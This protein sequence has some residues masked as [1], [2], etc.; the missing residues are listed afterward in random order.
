MYRA[1]PGHEDRYMI[2]CQMG[3]A[4]ALEREGRIEEA[5][6]VLSEAISLVPEGLEDTCPDNQY[7]HLMWLHQRTNAPGR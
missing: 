6:D 1:M 5:R 7:L 3:Y 4:S 2:A